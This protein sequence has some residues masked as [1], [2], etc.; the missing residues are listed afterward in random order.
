MYIKVLLEA[1]PGEFVDDFAEKAVRY[2][3]ENNMTVTAVFNDV[4]IKVKPT[5]TEEEILRKY[6]RAKQ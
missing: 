1:S 3:R 6:W 4:Y 5:T 2:S